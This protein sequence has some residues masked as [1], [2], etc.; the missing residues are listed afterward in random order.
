MLIG[1][2]ILARLKE[3]GKTQKW[4]ADELG[5]S[6]ARIQNYVKN[7]RTPD[8]QMLERIAA[9]MHTD[10]DWLNGADE[11]LSELFEAVLAKLFALSGQ[12]EQMGGAFARVALEALRVA[13]SL[14]PEGDVRL[15]ARLAAAAAWQTRAEQLR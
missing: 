11:Q 13:R 15:R 3:M 5:V 7:T 4:L 6:P 2:R 1:D 12:P 8:P 9:V 10:A 14:P